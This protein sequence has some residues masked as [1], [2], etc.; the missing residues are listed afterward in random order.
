MATI[1]LT[2]EAILDYILADISHTVEIC[3]G[4]VVGNSEAPKNW[5]IMMGSLKNLKITTYFFLS[6]EN[7]CVKSV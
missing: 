7:F 5:N 4:G 6:E 3:L 1:P 2:F